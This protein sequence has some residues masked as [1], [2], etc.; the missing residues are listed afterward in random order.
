MTIYRQ[1]L[2]LAAVVILSLVFLCL[3]SYAQDPQT[4]P[5]EIA[6]EFFGMPV[7]SS[8]YFFAKRVIMSYG[9]KWRGSPQTQAELEDMVWQEL[10]FSFEAYRR[11]IEVSQEEIGEEI[12]KILKAQKA[13]FN[14]RLDKEEFE[15]WAKDTLGVP[16]D[17]FMNQIEHLAKIEKLRQEVI[18]SIEPEVTDEEAYQKF[19]NEY[20]TLLVELI[21]FDDLEKAKDFYEKSILPIAD[22]APEQLVWDDLI[23]SDEAS[24]RGIKAEDEEV[25]KAVSALLRAKEARFKWQEDNE[26]F[27]KWIEETTGETEEGFRQRFKAFVKIGK[28]MNKISAKEEPEIKDKKYKKF[29]KNNKT[30]AQAYAEFFAAYK[31]TGDVLN[32]ASF[33]EAL[34]YYQKIDRQPGFWEDRKRENP[35]LFKQPGFVALDFLLNMWGF[36]KEDAYKMLDAEIGAYYP[37]SPIYKGYGVFKILKIRKAKPEEYEGRKDYYVERVKSIKKYDGFTAWVKEL[38]EQADIKR[39]IQ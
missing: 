35:D 10:L 5:P 24:K 36:K 26:S 37:P 25:D 17:M 32:F 16:V 28:L 38:K 12:E 22:N 9:A 18:D 39:F 34:A 27:K 11:G 7:P 33:E 30:Y 29:L 20:N 3:P 8:N 23:L 6:G 4:K 15:K 19:L 13:E 21:Q 14:W 1:S 2:F 31:P